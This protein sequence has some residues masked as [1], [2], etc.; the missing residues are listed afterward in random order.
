MTFSFFFSIPSFHRYSRREVIRERLQIFHKSLG[1][2][3]LFS[4]GIGL[5]V[6]IVLSL[7][8]LDSTLLHLCRSQRKWLTP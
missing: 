2:P 6:A 5:L 4:A 7:F 1:F 8:G 3:F